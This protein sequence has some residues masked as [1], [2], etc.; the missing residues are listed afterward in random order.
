MKYIDEI[1]FS[2]RWH[3]SNTVKNQEKMIAY[4]EKTL[5]YE[6][7]LV[8][9]LKT[10]KYIDPIVFEIHNYGFCYKKQGIPYIFEILS[11]KKEV[12]KTK[13]IKFFNIKILII[14]R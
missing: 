6:K 9:S 11:Y 1:L 5:E 14:V 8:K 3:N 7:K 10:T 4:T 2:Y 12:K 13:I